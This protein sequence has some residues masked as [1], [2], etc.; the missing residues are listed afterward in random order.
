MW[1]GPM[2][3]LLGAK[4]Q[5]QEAIG[6]Q[7]SPPSVVQKIAKTEQEF[8]FREPQMIQIG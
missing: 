2:S 5:E 7:R 6:V 8:P 1:S 3:D 4:K